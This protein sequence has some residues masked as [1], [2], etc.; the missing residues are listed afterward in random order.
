MKTKKKQYKDS[1]TGW[2]WGA[3]LNRVV[4]EGLSKGV[5]IEARLNDKIFFHEDPEAWHPRQ[6][7]TQGQKS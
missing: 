5:A 7:E 3:R 2:G 1:V 6:G 4:R